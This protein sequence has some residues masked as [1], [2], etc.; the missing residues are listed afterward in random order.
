MSKLKSLLGKQFLFLDGGTGSVLQSRGLKPGELSES[1]NIT[2]PEEIVNLHYSYYMAGSNIVCTN[3]FGAYDSKIE[4]TEEII[5]AAIENA[6]EA[7][8]RCSRETGRKDLFIA[9]DAGP[10]GKLLKPAG[11]LD[12]EDAVSLFK[13]TFLIAFK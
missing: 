13:R 8:K 11:D 9:Y 7:K 1:W 2:H 10:C 3:T 12:F 4:N 6:L 5:K